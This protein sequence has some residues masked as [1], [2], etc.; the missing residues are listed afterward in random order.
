MKSEG[1][2]CYVDES[3]ILPF[4]RTNLH[5]QHLSYHCVCGKS[6]QNRFFLSGVVDYKPK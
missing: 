4:L 3:Q 2:F 5:E 6:L 1:E